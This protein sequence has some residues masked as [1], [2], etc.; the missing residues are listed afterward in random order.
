MLN[1]NFVVACI[2]FFTAIVGY[3]GQLKL[4]ET[5]AKES[6]WGYRPADESISN[7]NPPAFSWHPQ[8]GLKWQ[9]QCASDSDFTDI[10]YQLSDIEFNV[11]CP[12]TVFKTGRYFWRYRGTDKEGIYTNWSTVRAFTIGEKATEM[13]L[14]KK[15]VLI[16]RVPKNHPRLFVR[17][18]NMEKLRTA[19]KSELKNVFDAIVRRCD[20]ILENPPSTEE[21]PKY[22]EG[23]VEFSEE[24][25]RIWRDNTRTVNAALGNAANLGFAYQ[26]SGDKKYGIEARRIL[27]ECAKWDPLGSTSFLY[28]DEAGMPYT[29][30]F[31]RT[32]TFVNDL[33][34]E[35]DKKICRDVMKVRGGQM[36]EFLCPRHFWSPYA[37]HDNRSWHFLGEAS[38]A[39]LGEIE[40]AQDWLWFTMNNF[41]CTYP[42][43]SDDDGGWAEGSN[44]FMF[45]Q[46]W[47]SWWADAVKEA[48]DI[49]IYKKP[50][51][52]QIGYY[53]M[54]L[55][56]PGKF[57]G[58]FGDW[59]CYRKAENFTGLMSIYASHTGNGYW[60][61]WVL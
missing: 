16:A 10:K 55:F 11:H 59:A 19:A 31:S 21:P 27:L 9:L 23:T 18:E 4:D 56:P 45:Y 15:E 12:D 52:S 57:D 44:Y 7:V 37:S 58:G 39:F 30:W 40:Q 32:Y 33:L 13:P 25:S 17:P 6:E 47:F 54:Y 3:A 2:C 14:P 43:W 36:Y 60:Q 8:Q 48:M 50:Y 49:D 51:Y 24:W 5:P 26:V 29:H 28:N 34:D 1:R 42:V 22:P 53:V 41:Y 61:W 46:K 20:K 35:Q 38:I